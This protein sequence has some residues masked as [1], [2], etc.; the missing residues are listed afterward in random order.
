MMYYS[1][2]IS[3]ALD[4]HIRVFVVIPKHILG[5]ADCKKSKKTKAS[6]NISYPKGDPELL[7]CTKVINQ[8]RE[9]DGKVKLQYYQSADKLF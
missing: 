6:G 4:D 7:R 8:F 3:D 5:Q 2:K 9:K 1:R